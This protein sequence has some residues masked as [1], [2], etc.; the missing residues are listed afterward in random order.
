MMPQMRRSNALLYAIK[1]LV[2]IHSHLAFY[3]LI[4]KLLVSIHSILLKG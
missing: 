3:E 2:W 1:W 4:G